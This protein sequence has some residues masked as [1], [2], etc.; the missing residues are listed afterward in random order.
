MKVVLLSGKAQA[1]K[2]TSALYMEE[3]LKQ[4]GK[5]VVITHFADLVKYA[6]EKFFGWDG[7]KNEAGRGLLQYV[8]TDI[9][10]EQS[11]DFWVNFILSMVSFFQYEW[12]YMLVADTR[13]PNEYELF[14]ENEMDAY[15]VR[16]ERWNHDDGLTE[17]QRCHESETALD[18]YTHDYKIC[19][20]GS[21]DDL[22]DEAHEI[23]RIIM[24]NGGEN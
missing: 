17:E 4:S 11:R 16:V 19:N 2:D 12:D 13:F 23:I 5:R 14:I 10:R 1:G 8:G 9:V 21:L 18:G 7:T 24:S 6:C 15:L 3:Y 20:N 22:R